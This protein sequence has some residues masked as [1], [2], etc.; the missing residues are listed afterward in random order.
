MPRGPAPPSAR[1]PSRPIPEAAFSLDALAPA[2]PVTDRRQPSDTILFAGNR[3]ET[4]PRALFTD[5]RLTPLER[6]AWQVCRLMLREDGISAFPTYERLRPY[7][8]ST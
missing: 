8:A 1:P 5:Y 4:V 7:L 6:N 2:P 3:H